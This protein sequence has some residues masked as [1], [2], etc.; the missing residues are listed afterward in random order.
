MTEVLGGSV[1]H[2]SFGITAEDERTTDCRPVDAKG[3]GDLF[4]RHL[5]VGRA[6]SYL[7]WP[8]DRLA[9]RSDPHVPFELA[10]AEGDRFVE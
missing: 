9:A 7:M 10:F 1:A 3:L 4:D 8:G 2:R 6:S 5:G